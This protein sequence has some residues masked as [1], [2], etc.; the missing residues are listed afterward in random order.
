MAPPRMTPARQLVA[1]LKL[2]LPN[3][4]IIV[5]KGTV[6]EDVKVVFGW[7]PYSMF[8]CVNLKLVLSQD[9]SRAYCGFQSYQL[10][11]HPPAH[12][13]TYTVEDLLTLV[14]Q[15]LQ[16][17]FNHVDSRESPEYNL[18]IRAQRLMAMCRNPDLYPWFKDQ[19]IQAAAE[20]AKM[21]DDPSRSSG[22][23][24]R[25]HIRG[26]IL[27]LISSKQADVAP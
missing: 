24:G 12:G 26:E 25:D 9:A 1:G 17:Y 5:E 2:S 13:G 14:R 11:R 19:L 3:T 15:G 22:V 10:P 27:A 6:Q 8:N 20:L 16:R 7:A 23:Q 4:S 21:N 18:I